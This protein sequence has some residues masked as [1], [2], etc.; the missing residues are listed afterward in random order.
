VKLVTFSPGAGRVPRPG[1]VVDDARI[2]DIPALV[3]PVEGST[4]P[5][6]SASSA[7]EP[8]RAGLSTR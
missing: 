3:T 8:R 2:V 4:S 6:C 1:L 5:P 7:V